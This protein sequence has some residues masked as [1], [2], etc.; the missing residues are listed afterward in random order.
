[1]REFDTT[2]V[3]QYYIRVLFFVCVNYGC[4]NNRYHS[5]ESKFVFSVLYIY[6]RKII[7]DK[8]KQTVIR[9]FI[10]IAARR[11]QGFNNLLTN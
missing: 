1:M 2:L 8:D 7:C 5:C 3:D 11:R 10:S 4:I 6:L 9:V